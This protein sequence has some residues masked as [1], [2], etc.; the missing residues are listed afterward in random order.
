MTFDPTKVKNYILL[1][2]GRILLKFAWEMYLMMRIIYILM[3]MLPV[4]PMYDMLTF[5]L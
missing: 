4:G 2:N 3:K 1:A 5:D